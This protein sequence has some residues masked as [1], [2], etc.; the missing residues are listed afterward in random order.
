MT[1]PIKKLDAIDPISALGAP[2]YLLMNLIHYKLDQDLRSSYVKKFSCSNLFHKLSL[3][4]HK[5]LRDHNDKL[6][7]LETYKCNPDITQGKI[8]HKT[9]KHMK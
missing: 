1:H 2:V 5:T 8:M 6:I 3:D 4:D 9:V 7:Y